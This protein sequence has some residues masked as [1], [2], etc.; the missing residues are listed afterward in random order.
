MFDTFGRQQMQK[1]SA[2][3]KIFDNI[4][5]YKQKLIYKASRFRKPKGRKNPL[6]FNIVNGYN[7][8][9]TRNTNYNNNN[10]SN[11]KI[12]NL[13][14]Q[15]KNIQKKQYGMPAQNQMPEN[16]ATRN[17]LNRMFS[18]QST[19]KSQK[20]NQNPANNNTNNNSKQALQFR[21]TTENQIRNSEYGP[22]FREFE[23]NLDKKLYFL[24]E[25]KERLENDLVRLMKT[26]LVKQ[27]TISNYKNEIV[28][29]KQ[30]MENDYNKTQVNSIKTKISDKQSTLDINNRE[31]NHHM[32]EIQTL[33][34]ALNDQGIL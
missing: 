15:N 3:G 31:L 14:H 9:P 6:Q 30:S 28:R 11:V 27:K 12:N 5:I 8:K 10:G 21:L 22:E 26:T 23:K 29:L 7:A 24:N 25:P 1:N 4:R 18:R 13:P 16:N 34:E 32:A 19:Y 20:M 17:P 33:E 2:Q